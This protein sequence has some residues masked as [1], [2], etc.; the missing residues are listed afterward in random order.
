LGTKSTEIERE[1][2]ERCGC[3]PQEEGASPSDHPN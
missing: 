3:D 2:V 1:V